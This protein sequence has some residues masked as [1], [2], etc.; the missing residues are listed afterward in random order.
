MPEV[1]EDAVNSLVPAG[2]LHCK[3]DRFSAL[4]RRAVSRRISS[5]LILDIIASLRPH[6]PSNRYVTPFF[7]RSR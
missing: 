2:M 6:P 1:D 4:S 7:S 3:R 5:P